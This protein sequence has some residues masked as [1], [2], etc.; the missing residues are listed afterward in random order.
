MPGMGGRELVT[1]VRSAPACASSTCRATRTTTSCG[2]HLARRGELPAEA[3]L[4]RGASA[5]GARGARRLKHPPRR[6]AV[7]GVREVA[8]PWTARS[9][10]G[11]EKS[12][13]FAAAA[14]GTRI[15]LLVHDPPRGAP[16]MSAD[17]PLSVPAAAFARLP[18]AWAP[19][20]LLLPLAAWI[21]SARRLYAQA[22][23]LDAFASL[24]RS[25]SVTPEGLVA[26]ALALTVGAVLLE[27]AVLRMVWGARRD[28][29]VRA[30]RVRA[31]AAHHDRGRARGRWRACRRA[32]GRGVARRGSV[33][34]ALAGSA[35]G[36]NG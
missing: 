15:A 16:R 26:L 9:G 1:R 31:L 3:V 32:A 5:Q 28:D 7:H 6:A 14:R 2:G 11:R 21:E 27:A 17:R 24:P 25:G 4:G 8:T 22:G 20:L 23:A 13:P 33:I 30:A 12:A 10:A 18:A 19:V 29:P 36:A 34:D 35:A